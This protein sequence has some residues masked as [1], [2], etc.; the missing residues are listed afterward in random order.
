MA[1]LL[2]LVWM[3]VSLPWRISWMFISLPA[4]FASTL[5]K[6]VGVH[7]DVK[8]LKRSESETFARLEAVQKQVE[9]S[10]R[11]RALTAQKLH[12]AMGE[13]RTLRKEVAAARD[14]EPGSRGAPAPSPRHDR[15][16]D[17]MLEALKHHTVLSVVLTA[18][19]VE[20]YTQ[21][22]TSTAEDRLVTLVGVM[23]GWNVLKAVF[24]G[25]GKAQGLTMLGALHLSAF[26][27]GFAACA[28]LRE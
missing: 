3:F 22:A 19:A 1:V 9:E 17:A 24:G 15:G 13:I 20:R 27:V 14:S 21:A 4:A 6:A 12:A 8:D 10:E 23:W 18:V 2:E 11:E 28:F 16:G 25:W 7:S 5:T 26:L